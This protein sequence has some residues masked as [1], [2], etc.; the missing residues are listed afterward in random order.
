MRPTLQYFFSMCIVLYIRNVSDILGYY[1]KLIMVK[2]EL[3]KGG[4]IVHIR[5]DLT[6]VA[7]SC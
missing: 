1:V 3:T 4:N 6:G 2:N 5:S 7:R